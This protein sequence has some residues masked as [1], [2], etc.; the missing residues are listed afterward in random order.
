MNAPALSGVNL[1]EN[2]SVAA[3]LHKPVS[4][5]TECSIEKYLPSLRVARIT[6]GCPE[7][8][9]LNVVEDKAYYEVDVTFVKDEET[10]T[11][12]IYDAEEVEVVVTVKVK[13]TQVEVNEFITLINNSN[14]EKIINA[15]EYKITIKE[16]NTITI[17]DY[18]ILEGE[19]QCI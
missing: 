11:N 10:I 14:E 1:T 7:Y 19:K 4:L 18:K 5:I 2:D 9:T 12:H 6:S 13:D 17:G 3:L 16:D 15:K 8:E